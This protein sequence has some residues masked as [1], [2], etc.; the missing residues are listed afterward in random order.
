MMDRAF[1][2]GNGGS[3]KTWPAQQLAQR[4]RYPVFHLDDFHWLPN[5]AGERPRDERKVAEAADGNSWIMEGIYG[6]VLRQVKALIWLDIPDSECISNLIQRGQTGGGTDE[7]FEELLEY[8]RGYRLRKNHMNSFDA[9]EQF[10]E[11]HSLQKLRLGSRSD[12][13]ALL[14]T[15]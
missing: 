4:L 9:H 12:A 7:Q 10:F 15:V 14:A 5:F 3:G 1:I 6:S 8:T 2:M 13:T 11:G